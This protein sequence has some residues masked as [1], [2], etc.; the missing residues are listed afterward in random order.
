MEATIPSMPTPLDFDA[1][2]ESKHSPPRTSKYG[3]VATIMIATANIAS[4]IPQATTTYFKSRVIEYND[5]L[6]TNFDGTPN[7]MNSL[8]HIYQ[9][10]VSN[11][12][13]F[14]LKEMIQQPDKDKFIEAM[15]E[16]VTS[17]IREDI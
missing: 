4:V 6:E 14:T 1:V 3:L 9:F 5:F 13:T 17:M 10:T 12:E 7:T 2:P 15:Y 11:N 8:S 16:E